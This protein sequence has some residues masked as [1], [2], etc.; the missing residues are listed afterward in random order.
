MIKATYSISH[1]NRAC[2]WS[3]HS[4]HRIFREGTSGW[5]SNNFSRSHWISSCMNFIHSFHFISQHWAT[6]PEKSGPLKA[7]SETYSVRIQN[8]SSGIFK[9]TNCTWDFTLAMVWLHYIFFT[10]VSPATLYYL[11]L[12]QEEGETDFVCC[13]CIVLRKLGS[14]TE[15]GFLGTANT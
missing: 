4:S 7:S 1:Y 10:C 8:K 2:I 3:V 14:G 15:K 9:V 5:G 11:N 6:M 13:I 12:L